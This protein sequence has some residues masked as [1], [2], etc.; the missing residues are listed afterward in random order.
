M[1]MIELI[2]ASV[3]MKQKNLSSQR[4]INFILKQLNDAGV[5]S[6]KFLAPTPGAMVQ[7]P[8]G[9]ALAE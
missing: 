9:T 3:E 8:I 1:P 6:P 4:T 5:K 2:G 7:L